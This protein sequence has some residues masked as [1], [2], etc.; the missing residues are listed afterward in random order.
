[1]QVNSISDPA[2]FR[3]AVAPVYEKYKQHRRDL[4]AAALEQV[5]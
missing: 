1:M 5:K 2:A 3:K 4:L